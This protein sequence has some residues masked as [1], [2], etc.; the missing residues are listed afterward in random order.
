MHP[1]PQKMP[2]IFDYNRVL[3][4]ILYVCTTGNITFYQHSTIQ[5]RRDG[6][7]SVYIYALKLII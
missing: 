7:N 3:W 4:W 2:L 1:R 5:G 6:D